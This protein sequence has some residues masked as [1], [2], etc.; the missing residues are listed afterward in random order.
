MNNLFIFSAN[1]WF[2]SILSMYQALFLLKLEHRLLDYYIALVWLYLKNSSPYLFIWVYFFYTHIFLLLQVIRKDIKAIKLYI[3]PMYF[4]VFCTSC[5]RE[6]LGTAKFNDFC[7]NCRK[8]CLNSDTEAA[9]KK[10][11]KELPSIKRI[12]N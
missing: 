12:K 5:N 4:V 10:Q 2:K 7:K 1:N 9:Q 6:S 3:H 8:E 11:E